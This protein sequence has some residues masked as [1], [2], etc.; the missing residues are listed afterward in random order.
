MINTPQEKID[1]ILHSLEQIVGTD[2][3]IVNQNLMTKFV[4]D[5]R[6]RYHGNAIAV[7]KPRNTS[8]IVAIIKLC[9]THSIGIVPQG[10]NTSL[11]GGSIPAKDLD[12]PQI[13]INLSL[14]NKIIDVDLQ[15]NSI[16]VEAGTTLDQL[17][18]TAE[19]NDR[20]FPLSIGS[21]GSCQIGG[22]IATNAGGIHVIK[23]GMMNN[24]V[25]GL[26]VVLA[27]GTII[28][29][30]LSLYKNNI[31]FDLKQLFI[32]SEGCFGIITKA[33]LKLYP[34][35]IN[36]ITGLIGLPDIN[37][38]ITLANQL[39]NSFNCCAFEIINKQ[40]QDIY[41]YQFPKNKFPITNNYLVLFEIEEFNTISLANEV[42]NLLTQSSI[43][44]TQIIITI[45][46][47]QRRQLWQMRENIPLA[48]KAFGN[49]VK[50][51]ISLPISSVDNFLQ[52]NQKNLLDFN[53]QIQIIMFGHLGDGNLHYNIY[54][55]DTDLLQ[56]E[57][58]INQ[59]V[60]KDVIRHKGSIS[61]EH[62]IGQLKKQWYKKLNPESYNL[63]LNIK[64]LLDP[65]N[66]MNPN[67]LFTFNSVEL[68]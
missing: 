8:Q 49:M 34:K 32:G 19:T 9:S 20:Y 22:N 30:L 65:E 31:N 28:N 15:N 5:W 11:C 25:L 54:I 58:S 45:N 48:E 41:N 35:P 43:E 52:D 27:N 39:R 59:L 64:N 36:Y 4:I 60:Y 57:E 50:H 16:T 7:I 18:K 33:I 23:Y 29:Q 53:P 37:Q 68:R 61:A 66:I 14:M 21:Q 6:G 38:S 55:P 63:A 44:Q 12:K 46:L 40:V 13:I 17:I 26:E 56:Y 42:F 24:L 47:E 10:G 3:L 1:N 62:G 51:D 67:K 2:N